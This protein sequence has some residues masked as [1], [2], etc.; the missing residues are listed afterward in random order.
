MRIII[1]VS[2]EG[3][4]NAQLSRHFGR[5]PY[6]AVVDLDESGRISKHKTAPNVGGR[7]GGSGRRADSI[8]QFEPNAI[9]VYDM[10]PR[11]LSI[12]QNA[13]VAV[14]RTGARIVREAVAAYNRNELEELTE[15]C[16]E[17]RH[18]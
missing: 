18:A 4:L 1:P 7:F 12:F 11:G 14:L 13:G 2:D 9:I 10:G 3:G 8:L 16:R 17:A 15:G 5:A 6:L